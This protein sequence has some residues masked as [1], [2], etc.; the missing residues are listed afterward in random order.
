LA[1]GFQRGFRISSGSIIFSSPGIVL[2]G[3]GH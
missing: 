3:A 2:D 1:L